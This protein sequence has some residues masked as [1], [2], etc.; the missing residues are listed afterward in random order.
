[1]K[2]SQFAT[3]LSL[4]EDGVWIDIGDGARL[5]IA[6]IGNPRYKEALRAKLKPYRSKA[7]QAALSDEQWLHINCEVEAKTILLDWEGWEQDN[8]KKATYSEKAAYQMLHGL[9]DF[10]AMVLRLAEEQ[11]TFALVADE[12]AGND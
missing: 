3:D 7:A 6:R 11:A 5:K 1:M 2:F 9:K 10:R 8:G 12:E 4:E